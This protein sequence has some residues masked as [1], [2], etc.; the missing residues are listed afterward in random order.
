MELFGRDDI[1]D[2][3]GSGVLPTGWGGNSVRL[4]MDVVNAALPDSPISRN[5][6]N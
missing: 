5:L 3:N 1:S 2:F 6:S 4:W